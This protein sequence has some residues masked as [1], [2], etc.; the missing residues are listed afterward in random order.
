MKAG[1]RRRRTLA[2]GLSA[3]VLAGPALL[4]HAAGTAALQ[5]VTSEAATSE[6]AAAHE[7]FGW[8][9]RHKKEKKEAPAKPQ[10]WMQ[11]SEPAAMSIAVE[12][13][14]F[15][16][17]SD[18]YQ[19]MRAR[20]VSL[21]FLDE[22]RLLFSFRAPGLIHR[23][24]GAA[25]A[26]G[27]QTGGEGEEREIRALVLTLPAGGVEAQAVWTLHDEDPYLWMLKDGH[28]LLRDRNNLAVGDAALELKPYL[29]FPGPL[30]LVELDPE[31]QYL[32]TDSR[33]P[34]GGA[35]K[36]GEVGSP[37]TAETRVTTD[38]AG[39]AGGGT[40]GPEIVL[41]IVRRATGKVMLVSRVRV[42]VHLPINADG[43]V[44]VLQGTRWEWMLNLDLF[45]GGS[46]IL[47]SVT[48]HCRPTIQFV[49]QGEALATTCDQDGA[50]RLLALGT[51]GKEMWEAATPA[52]EV[53]PIVVAGASGTR[54]ARETLAVT[55]PVG[56]YSPLSFDDVMGQVVRVY[57]AGSGKVLLKAPASPVLDGGGNVAISPS[58]RRVAVLDGSSIRVYE[59]GGNGQDGN[60][61][62]AGSAAA[63]KPR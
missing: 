22:N 44:E 34:Q 61:L 40:G 62:A 45:S 20:M 1:W 42:K 41:R 6:A 35:A 54:I 14:G 13:L 59:L 60:G 21:D 8:A 39:N 50:L 11:P 51:S 58:G 2:P 33:E 55:H 9:W 3:L 38:D 46:R 52:T 15:A 18:F 19:G 37:A 30:E 12:K 57:D 10:E 28:F 53:W 25:P 4:L 24:A 16:A 32:V 48:S 43:Y 7:G 63:V 23:P 47:G 56:P 26:G 49:A 5:P 27:D 29:T 36:P 31:D 17:P